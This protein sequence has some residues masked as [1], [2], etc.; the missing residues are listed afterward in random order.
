MSP[1]PAGTIPQT[2]KITA[3]DLGGGVIQEAFG[4]KVPTGYV[5][6]VEHIT[7]VSSAVVNPPPDMLASISDRREVLTS[8]ALNVVDVS[9]SATWDR[10]S[11]YPRLRIDQGNELHIMWYVTGPGQTC[12]ASIQYVLIPQRRQ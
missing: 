2:V 12:Y 6:E 8:G 10:R 1:Q 7:L 9:S 11:Y 3:R 5:M 4:P